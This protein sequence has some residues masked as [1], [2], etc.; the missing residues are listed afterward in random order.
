MSLH[1]D[2]GHRGPTFSC[3]MRAL[4]K[5]DG[6]PLPYADAQAFF[7]VPM[8]MRWLL[9]IP[10]PIHSHMHHMHWHDGLDVCLSTGDSG[11]VC[12]H[13]NLHLSSLWGSTHEIVSPRW[14]TPCQKVCLTSLILNYLSLFIDAP[15]FPGQWSVPLMPLIFDLALL[16]DDALRAVFAWTCFC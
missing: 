13:I 3:P 10:E 15:S 16:Y 4:F 1:A 7:K 9:C 14:H 11:V 6:S 5:E 8:I 12:S 2:E